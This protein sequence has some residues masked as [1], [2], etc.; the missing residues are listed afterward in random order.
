MGG[1]LSIVYI[2]LGQYPI[3]LGASTGSFEVTA[4]LTFLGRES[5]AGG[6]NETGRVTGMHVP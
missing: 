5:K 4:W 3:S 1:R 2:A 6:W